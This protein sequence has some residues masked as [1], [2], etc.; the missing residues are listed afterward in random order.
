MNPIALL[1]RQHP[2]GQGCFP[3]MAAATMEQAARG[4]GEVPNAG[5]A[6]GAL[7]ATLFGVILGGGVGLIAGVMI[8]AHIEKQNEEER[9]YRRAGYSGR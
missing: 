5:V 3:S 9:R 8:G 1:A 7:G 4:L 6:I 2:L